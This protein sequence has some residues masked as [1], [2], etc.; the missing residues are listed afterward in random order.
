MNPDEVVAAVDVADRAWNSVDRS[1]SPSP[2]SK[3]PSITGRLG[4]FL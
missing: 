2:V 3:R 4:A 1:T